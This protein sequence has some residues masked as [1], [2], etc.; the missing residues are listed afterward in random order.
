MMLFLLAAQNSREPFFAPLMPFVTVLLIVVVGVGVA[1]ALLMAI[2]GRGKGKAV[3]LTY[4]DS[5]KTCPKP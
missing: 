5:Q 4:T 1:G 2:F 3:E